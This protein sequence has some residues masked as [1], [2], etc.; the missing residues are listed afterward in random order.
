MRILISNIVVAFLLIAC[1]SAVNNAADT[2]RNS[3]LE[4]YFSASPCFGKCKVYNI[5]LK[6][7]IMELNAMENTLMLGEFTSEL[8]TDELNTLWD[9]IETNSIMS[10]LKVEEYG[11]EMTDLPYIEMRIKINDKEK[12]IKYRNQVPKSI[13]QIDKFLR[14]SINELSRWESKK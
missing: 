3:K 8:S 12:I 11:Q 13:E 5:N 4:I 10:N 14:S 2:R 9:I 7:S 1:S 6:N